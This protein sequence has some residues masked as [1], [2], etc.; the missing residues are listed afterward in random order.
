MKAL[1]FVAY[2]ALGVVQFLAVIAGLQDWLG[3]HWIISGAI[4]TFAIFIAYIPLIGSIAGFMGAT[5]TWGWSNLTA[6]LLFFGPPW[7]Y[8]VSRV[9]FWHG[10]RRARQPSGTIDL[11][12]YRPVARPPRWRT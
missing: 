5:E 10:H 11:L 1:F 12:L 9:W 3:F 6:A 8:L 7:I 2:L 4:A